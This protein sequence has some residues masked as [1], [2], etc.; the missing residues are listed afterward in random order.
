M[1]MVCY[2]SAHALIGHNRIPEQ[3]ESIACS[4]LL[5][6]QGG[7]RIICREDTIYKGRIMSRLDRIQIKGFKSIRELDLE[8][9]PLNVL[10]GAN[11]SGKS[12]FIDVF[13]L[14]HQVAELHLQAYVQKSGRA[15]SFLHYGQKT[16]DEIFIRLTFEDGEYGL[17][18]EPAV[19]DTLYISHEV[20]HYGGM[21]IQ[22]MAQP[23]QESWLFREAKTQPGGMFGFLFNTLQSWRVYHFHD[24]SDSAKVKKAG[25]LNDNEYLR[26]DASNLAAYLYLLKKTQI[27]HYQRIVKTIQM[28]NP[29]FD[30]FALRPDPENPDIIMLE[31]RERGSD[32]ILKAHVLSD[33]ALRF[34]CLTTLLM[35][36]ELPSTILIDEPELGLHPYALSLVAGMLRSASVSTQVIVTT[37]SSALVD[38]FDPEDVIVVERQDGPSV[39]NRLSTEK[40][41]NWLEDY[42]LG[43]IWEKNVVG[44]APSR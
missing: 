13:E 16:T 15:N 39:F 1:S 14:L 25:N 17:H 28:A 4:F 5:P 37:Q 42:S 41:A 23:S 6:N 31:W 36:P 21:G 38:E 19:D 12:N 34:I 30:D 40:I 7:A 27:D 29:Y 3:V 8:L 32:S 33:G 18:L 43:E 24:T 9:R 44:G 20:R 2:R 22:D 11:G 35:Q 26:T 10:I